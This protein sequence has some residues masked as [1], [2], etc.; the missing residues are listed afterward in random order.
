MPF[1]A[2]KVLGAASAHVIEGGE[3]IRDA[4]VPHLDE[5]HAPQAGGVGEGH[6]IVTN[7]QWQ[8]RIGTL[9]AKRAI[10][11]QTRGTA[12]ASVSSAARRVGGQAHREFPEQRGL[13]QGCYRAASA[14]GRRT[15][16]M[17]GTWHAH[18]YIEPVWLSEGIVLMCC[19]P[20]ALDGVVHTL[21]SDFHRIATG[22]AAKRDQ[23]RQVMKSLTLL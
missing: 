20:H 11:L 9:V 17:L 19:P 13:S 23:R 1:V 15:Q 10:H 4:I 14:W 2:C 18:A 8:G 6:T 12:C 16:I 21:T 3:G 22:A 5:D 7:E